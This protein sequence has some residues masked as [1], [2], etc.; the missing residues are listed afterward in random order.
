MPMQK[1]WQTPEQVCL[2]LTLATDTRQ[3]L[4]AKQR[5]KIKARGKKDPARIKQMN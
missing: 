2:S 4:V 5:R 1:G 3:S